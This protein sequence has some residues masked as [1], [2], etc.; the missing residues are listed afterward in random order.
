MEPPRSES[1]VFHPGRRAPGSGEEKEVGL[2]G[3]CFT[4]RRQNVCAVVLDAEVGK[5]G[6]RRLGVVEGIGGAGVVT[7]A[8]AGAGDREVQTGRREELL[9]QLTTSFRPHPIEKKAG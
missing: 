1:P 2:N 9:E 3:G 7:G 4:K 8:D 6:V 5:T